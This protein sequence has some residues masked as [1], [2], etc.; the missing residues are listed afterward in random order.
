MHLVANGMLHKV[1]NAWV[2]IINNVF[3]LRIDLVQ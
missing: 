3:I 1:V 2:E